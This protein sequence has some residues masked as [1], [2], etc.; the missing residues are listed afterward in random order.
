MNYDPKN[1]VTNR[2]RANPN[3]SPDSPLNGESGE[4]FV[5]KLQVSLAIDYPGCTWASYAFRRYVYLAFYAFSRWASF[6]FKCSKGLILNS[7]DQ[8]N[9]HF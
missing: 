9:G 4:V 7:E 1:F 8:R 5:T 2:S 3:T 6:G